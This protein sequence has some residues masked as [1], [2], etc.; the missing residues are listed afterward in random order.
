MTCAD[1]VT[2][3]RGERQGFSAGRRERTTTDLTDDTD[4]RRR[5]TEAQ[6]HRERRMEESSLFPLCAS[7]P[8]WLVVL[9][10]WSV[11]LTSLA[12][13]RELGADNML[14]PNRRVR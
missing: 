1:R 10:P 5:T 9:N 4:G 3:R 13:R 12:L 2:E 7:A 6:R 14:K 11:F 8:L